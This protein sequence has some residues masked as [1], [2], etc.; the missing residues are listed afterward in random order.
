MNYLYLLLLLL[1]FIGCSSVN[2]L[3][4]SVKKDITQEYVSDLLEIPQDVS[5]YTSDIDY[6]LLQEQ[7]NFEK[8]YFR[9]WNI[10]KSKLP[11]DEAMWPHRV[12]TAGDTYGENLQLLEKDF[13][14]NLH[15]NANYGKYLTLNK[16]AVTL[17]NLNIRALPTDNAVLYDPKKAGEGFPFD[18]MQNSTISA[19]KPVLVS[20]YSKNREWVFIES[21]FAFGW[22]KSNEIVFLDDKYANLWKNAQQVFLTKDSQAIYSEE[23]DFLFN[24]RVGMMLALIDE[25]HDTY[26]VL[27]ISS[28]KTKAYYHKSI[29]SKKIAHKGIMNFN[30]KN[31]NL[32]LEE[33]SKSKYGWG[34]IY[35]QRDC[36][37]TLRD[38]FIPFGLWL[39]RNSSQ[40]ALSGKIESV[41]HMSHEEKLSFIKETAV[42]FKTL[43]YKAGHIGLY[44]GVFND[45]VIVYQNVWGIKTKKDLDDGRFVIG[46][47]IFSTLELGNNLKEYDPEGSFL[48]KLKSTSKL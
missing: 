37:S 41:E 15:E 31:I 26:T 35:N 22:L 45:N 27:T 42:P 46:K 33:I 6:G 32:V 5:F 38:F 25:S 43:L 34:G 14:D 1:Y 17:N 12:Y 36:S 24:S 18:Y 23:N 19:N 44:V 47:P 3:S 2:T 8:K 28:D 40:Q 21:S 13:F 11:L 29:I 4:T 16:K 20:H 7:E 10:Q 30:E 39:P 9:V 48:N